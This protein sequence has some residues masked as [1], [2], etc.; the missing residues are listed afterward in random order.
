[1]LLLSIFVNIGMWFERFVI[2]ATSLTRDYLPSSWKMFYPTWA[3]CLQ[4]LGGFGLFS[5]LFLLFVRFLPVIALAEVK[6]C[7][8]AVEAARASQRLGSLQEEAS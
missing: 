8:P 1:M 4:L 7:L 2:V 3:D 6:A 5:T